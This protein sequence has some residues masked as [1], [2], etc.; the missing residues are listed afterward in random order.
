MKVVS[1]KQEQDILSETKYLVEYFLNTNKSD[2]EI[3]KATGISSSTVGRRL[4]NKTRILDAFPEV[5][6]EIYEKV[7]RK[8]QENKMRGKII[9]G[10]TSM[11]NSTIINSQE[12]GFDGYTKL[13]LD[14]LF[15]KEDN[16]WVFLMHI[17]LHF[18][19][20][21]DSLAQLFQL[22]E[23]LIVKKFLSLN[24]GVYNSL[25][26][27]FYRDVTD[28]EVAKEKFI[29]YYRELLT[30]IKNKSIEEENVLKNQITDYAVGEYIKNHQGTLTEEEVSVLLDYQLKYALS[31]D[32]MIK[33]FVLD[34]ESYQS[35]VYEYVI[36][37]PYLK[38]RLDTLID[39]TTKLTAMAGKRG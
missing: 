39:H 24:G 32:D 7:M 15:E 2:I 21:L 25:L 14:V 3:S 23:K 9:G 10:Q 38:E 4:T 28:Q 27:L 5:G 37:K 17:A 6:P 30:A 11:L 26:Y 29:N 35:K 8:R 12:K 36:D 20:K 31:F 19:L 1:K 13:R 18:R 33:K 22:D 16:Q 34:K